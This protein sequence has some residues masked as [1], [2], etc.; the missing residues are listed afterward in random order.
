MRRQ[1]RAAYI[2]V[3][4]DRFPDILVKKIV[5]RRLYWDGS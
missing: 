2:K 5:S 3:W 4:Q 1:V